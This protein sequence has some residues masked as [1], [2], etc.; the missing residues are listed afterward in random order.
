MSMRRMTAILLAVLVVTG[1]SIGVGRR[2]QRV[3][4]DLPIVDHGDAA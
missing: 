4:S 2:A 1:F 3:L